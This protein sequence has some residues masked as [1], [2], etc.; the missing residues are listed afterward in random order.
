MTS[1]PTEAKRDEGCVG[2]GA[3]VEEEVAR[4]ERDELP[5]LDREGVGPNW[6]A[7]TSPCRELSCARTASVFWRAVGVAVVGG[8]A[9]GDL[10]R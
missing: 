1:A 8:R 3:G 5:E 4:G 9:V 7:L 2:G 6:K 10:A